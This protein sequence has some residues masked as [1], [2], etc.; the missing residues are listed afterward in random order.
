MLLPPVALQ[1]FLYAKAAGLGSQDTAILLSLY[2]KLLGIG[3]E[4]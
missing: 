3:V 4:R 2:E 1:S